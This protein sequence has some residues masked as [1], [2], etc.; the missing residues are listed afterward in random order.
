MMKLFY[1]VKRLRGDGHLVWYGVKDHV[2]L[3]KMLFIPKQFSGSTRSVL[4]TLAAYK[5]LS[6]SVFF[7]Q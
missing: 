4:I 2:I 7:H 3:L 1:N 6:Y 5:L